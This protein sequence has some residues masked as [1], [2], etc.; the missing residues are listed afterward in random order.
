MSIRSSVRIYQ[1][2]NNYRV[3]RLQ[4]CLD[5]FL[6]DFAV[7]KKKRSLSSLVVHV[8]S[9]SNKAAKELRT[10]K[11]E[12]LLGLL[13]NKFQNFFDLI[14]VDYLLGGASDRPVLEQALHELDSE[15]F[16]LFEEIFHALQKLSIEVLETAYL[17]Q[18]YE[19]LDGELLVFRLKWSSVTSNDGSQDFQKLSK[20]VMLFFFI[21]NEQD[22]IHDLRADVRALVH[23]LA[24][25][26]VEDCL[27]VVTFPRVFAVKQV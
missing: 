8:L 26:S 15:L 21:C 18:R 14:D 7:Q 4:I 3:T 27:Q 9:S 24:V 16:I 20:T 5:Y 25:Y 13:S 17:V 22:E 6:D 2:F 1:T 23:V 12:L 19:N 10:I 11:H